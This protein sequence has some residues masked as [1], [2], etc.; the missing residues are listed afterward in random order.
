MA[1]VLTRWVIFVVGSNSVR[2]FLSFL[3]QR[4]KVVGKF[5]KWAQTGWRFSD[6]NSWRMKDGML[7]RTTEDCSWLDRDLLCQEDELD[8]SRVSPAWFGGDLASIGGECQ[9]GDGLDWEEDLLECQEP[10]PLS[11]IVF[12]VLI[13][14]FCFGILG[15][16]IVVCMR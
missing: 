8:I 11:Q 5:R 2:S 10:R 9:C 16:V 14:L 15:C 1:T 12:I 13:C 7:C 6:W 4:T 3:R